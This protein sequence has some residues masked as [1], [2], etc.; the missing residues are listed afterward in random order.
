[1]S[2]VSKE[3]LF[4]ARLTEEDVEI[5]GVGTVRIRALS[6][7]EVLAF[8]SRKVEDVADMERALLSK[9]LVEP[10]LTEDEVR[11]WQEASAAGELE[12]VTRAISRLSGMDETAAK[13][14]V[15]RFRG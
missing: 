1:M 8:R 4:K 2:N 3:T 12:P 11:Q 9:G 7:A 10:A 14:A 6:R 13:E 15:K 5:P